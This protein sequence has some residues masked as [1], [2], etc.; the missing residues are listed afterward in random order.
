MELSASASSP[1]PAGEPV[2][3]GRP[4]EWKLTDV[5]FGSLWFLALFLALPIPFV[6]PFLAIYGED[7]TGYFIAT[8]IAGAF[9][10]VG[11]IVVA[12]WFTFRKYGGGFER[13]GFSDAALAQ[14]AAQTTAFFVIKPSHRPLPKDSSRA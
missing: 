12:G 10:E 7:S 5:L 1:P 4:V 9:S 6:I 13:L 14:S 2:I 11:L 8:L 3:G